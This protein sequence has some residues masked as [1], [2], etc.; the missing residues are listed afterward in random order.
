MLLILKLFQ[1]MIYMVFSIRI[2][3][4]FYSRMKIIFKSSNRSPCKEKAKTFNSIK[5]KTNEEM[6]STDQSLLVSDS[7]DRV[8]PSEE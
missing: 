2:H 8:D 1:K 6:F 7:V 5:R 4:C 3:V